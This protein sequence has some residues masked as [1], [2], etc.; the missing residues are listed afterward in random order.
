M[1]CTVTRHLLTLVGVLT[2]WYVLAAEPTPK[3]DLAEYRTVETAVAAQVRLA[4]AGAAGQT[5]YLGAAVQRDDRGRVVVEAV[6]PGSPAERA[7]LKKGDVVTR[8]GGQAVKTPDAFREWLQTH[9][10]GEAVKLT[11]IRGELPSEVTATLA[12]TSRPMKIGTQPVLFG[13]ELGELQEGGGVRV[14][15]VTP[16]TPAAAAGVKAGDYIVKLEGAEFTRPGR[17][18]DVLYEKRPGDTL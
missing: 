7:G 9:G 10:P 12:A 17:L 11:L 5:G 13:A 8:V 2:G 1:T 14:E 3:L 6:Q 4:A 18:T 16:N 15:G